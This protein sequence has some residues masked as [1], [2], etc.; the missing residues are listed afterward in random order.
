MNIFYYSKE[1]VKMDQS[2]ENPNLEMNFA[3]T[4]ILQYCPAD[5]VEGSNCPSPDK[6]LLYCPADEV[7]GSNCPFPDKILQYCPTD[8]FEGSNCPFPD[9]ILQ[10]CPAD[11]VEG[12]NCPSPDKILQYCP[13]DEVEGSNCPSPDPHVSTRRCSSGR[14]SCYK[15]EEI[16]STLLNYRISSSIYIKNSEKNSRNTDFKGSL[17]NILFF[18]F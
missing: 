10:Y 15:L 1:T 18:F 11:E 14:I 8:E 6:I 7:E 12:S 5:E 3:E 2:D 4:K 17:N 9:K 13:A 16:Q